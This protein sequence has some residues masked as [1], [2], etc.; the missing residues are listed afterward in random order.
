MIQHLTFDQSSNNLTVGGS[1]TWS[2][3]SS[4]ES[5]DAYDNTIT[6]FSDSGSS[7]ITLT[8]TQRDGGT[9]TT[10]FSN[11]Q[12][13]VTSIANGTGLDGTFT[14]SGTITLDLSELA[15][16][17]TL[18]GTDE[19]IV[20][21]GNA[22]RK[23]AANAIGLSIFNNDAG[24]IT[25]ASVPSVG[26]GQID[27]RTSGNGLSGSMDA[28]ANQSGNTTFTVTSNATTAATASTIAYRDSSADLNVRLLRANYG[29]QSTISGAIAFRVN[30]STDNY[31]R[32]CSSPSAIRAFI[33]AGTSSSSGVTSVATGNGIS[34]GTI[35]ST[36]TLTVGAG[37]G[38]SQSST[39]LLVDSTVVRTSGNQSIAGVKSFSGKIGA[40]GGID[41]LTIANGGITGSNYNISGVNQLSI[42]DPG[43][44]LVFNGTTTLFLNVIDDSVD[45]KLRLTNAV[46][47][48]LNGTAKITNLANPTAA[49][50][51]ATKSYV[52]SA[53]SGATNNYVTGGNVTS[54]TVTL[55]RQGLGNVSFTINNSQ[56][57]NGRGFTTNTGTTTASNTQTFTNKSGN[58]S[59]WTNDSGYV[60]SSGG[61]MSTWK[62]TGDSGG[63]ETI[64]DNETVDIGGGTGITTV[65]SGATITVKNTAPN[66]VQTTITGNAGSATVLQTARTIAGVS[67]NGSANISLNNNAITNG[68]GYITSGSL[69]TVNNGTLTMTT[70]TGLDGG[71][72]FTANQSGNS[73]FAVTLDLSEL[74][75]MTAAIQPT[76]DEVILLDNGAE[77]RKRFSEIFG[78]NA[79]NSTTIP[80]NNNQLTNGAGYI[81]SSSI[82]TVG[83]GSLTMSTGT[84]LD[85]GTQV[86]F[87]NQSANSNF[88]ITLDLSELTDMTATMNTNDEFIVLDSNAERRKRA[89]EIGLSI[90]SNDA[91]F[92]TNTGTITGSGTDNQVALF[93]GSTAIEGSVNL[94]QGSGALGELGIAG[95]VNHIG[96]TNERFGWGLG[97]FLV[98]AGTTNQTFHVTTSAVKLGYANGNSFTLQTDNKGIRVQDSISGGS[99]TI[100]LGTG[101]TNSIQLSGSSVF[102]NSGFLGPT[103]ELKNT[104]QLDLG[105]YTATSY[106]AGSSGTLSP[107]QNFQP[108]SSIGDDTLTSLTVDGDGNV[109]RGSQEATWSFT[110]AQ[111]NALSN[112]RVNLLAAPGTNKCLCVE[113]SNWLI[114][115]NSS[116]S[117]SFTSDITCE[118]AG[119]TVFS[120]A[121]R[122]TK[123]RLTTMAGS[124]FNGIGI[125]TRDVPE[126]DKQ[127][128]F[129][130]PMT[131]R[132]PGGT[133]QFPAKLISVRLKIKYRVFD[134]ATF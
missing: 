38:L 29:N 63:V 36:G 134:K 92:T 22:E 115:S 124:V 109:V 48:D 91:G 18:V 82:P 96:G 90:F 84:G 65:R 80:T 43:E 129:N 132:I 114:E 94:T 75:D 119:A 4:A 35:T 51:G 11:P 56:I 83:N 6:G 41:G 72:T 106:Q 107:T 46:E 117:G 78:N 13:T 19:F 100:F 1:V 103:I 67:F 49:Q 104:G 3:G 40:D 87:A 133:N 21:D 61:S 125:Y 73:T 111:L 112:T 53:V 93:N 28:T 42:N 88:T 71:T 25:S 110:R 62:L 23:K 77:R 113:E 74:T 52:D 20:L 127:L 128:Q 16:A 79:Y 76:V 126:T 7:T 39:G 2:G 30:N 33:G 101:N 116:A 59:Q 26:N 34:G 66:I 70:S 12:G 57:T 95:Y 27:G 50:D 54:G 24:F 108:G 45:N 105:A 86:F 64:T 89:G 31:T 118:I 99:G 81:T 58:I 14:T 102:L 97:G 120:V 10:S 60:T 17:G 5:N 37:D 85:G 122:I 47:L 55:N 44:G 68:A 131:I 121:T 32:Y 123:A 130:Q 8:L 69:P 98:Q 9:L 15:V